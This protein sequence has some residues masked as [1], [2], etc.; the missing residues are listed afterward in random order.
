MLGAFGTML[1]VGMLKGG[2]V[3]MRAGAMLP[4]ALP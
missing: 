1:G 4:P 3:G 2:M